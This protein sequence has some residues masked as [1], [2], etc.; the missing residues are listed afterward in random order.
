MCLKER[1]EKRVMIKED[2]M[3]E[4]ELIDDDVFL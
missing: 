2:L 3:K 1:K 4:L